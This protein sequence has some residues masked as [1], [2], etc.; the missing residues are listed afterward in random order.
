MTKLEIQIPHKDSRPSVAILPGNLRLLPG[1]YSCKELVPLNDEYF[2]ERITLHQTDEPVTTTEISKAGDSDV[3]LF[4]TV[5][6][7]KFRLHK[8]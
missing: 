3:I 6:E 8:S 7:K 5:G 2:Q 4:L 1:L